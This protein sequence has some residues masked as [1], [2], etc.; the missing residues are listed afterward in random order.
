MKKLFL[1]LSVITAYSCSSEEPEQ[2]AINSGIEQLRYITIEN[3]D[4][5]LNLYIHALG[6]MG[7]A[8][9]EICEPLK[10]YGD[11]H[12]IAYKW[13]GDSGYNDTL[14]VNLRD[15]PNESITNFVLTRK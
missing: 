4:S 1:I 10:V 12:S 8:P 5:E 14:K 13:Q 6:G 2:N 15:K 11:A 7:T 9:G 3:G